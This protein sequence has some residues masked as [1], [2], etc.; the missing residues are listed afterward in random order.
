MEFRM[1]ELPIYEIITTK[2]F[3]DAVTLKQEEK[4]TRQCQSQAAD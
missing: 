1:T 2:N 4:N 3:R